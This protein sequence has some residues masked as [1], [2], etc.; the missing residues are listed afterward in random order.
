MVAGDKLQIT[1]K[2]VNYTADSVVL[3]A[4]LRVNDST[5]YNSPMGVRYFELISQFLQLSKAGTYSLQY[6]VKMENGYTDGDIRQLKVLENGLLI[7]E[8]ETRT[9]EGNINLTLVPQQGHINRQVLL[10]NR[11]AELLLAEINQLKSYQYG[12]VE[13]TASKLKALLLEKQFQTALS[14]EFSGEKQIKNCINRLE[15]FQNKNG[16]WG[17]WDKSPTDNFMTI[18]AADALTHAQKAG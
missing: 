4:L 8:G 17:W 10:S 1:G 5:L 11:K 7:N 3:N 9:L 16:S 18:Y 13:Q 12:C 14:V 6:S 15:K 2:T